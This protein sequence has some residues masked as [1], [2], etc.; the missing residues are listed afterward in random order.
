M[1]VHLASELILTRHLFAIGSAALYQMNKEHEDQVVI[2][3]QVPVKRMQPSMWVR[4]LGPVSLLV[5][6]V[7]LLLRSCDLCPVI[8]EIMRPV[9]SYYWDHAVCVQ[10]LLISCGLRPTFTEIMRPVSNYHWD[11]AVW[12]H[13]G[14][15]IFCPFA[16]FS[17]AVAKAG[18]EK[19]SL[20]SWYCN[21]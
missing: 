9:S 19:P 10:L 7:Q 18:P 3:R 1:H 14:G 4:K 17:S 11:Y 21:S 6:C 5:A 12:D 8:T 15:F 16:I 13:C 2:I 20:P